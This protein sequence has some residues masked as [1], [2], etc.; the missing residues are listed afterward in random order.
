MILLL[1]DPPAAA[2]DPGDRAAAAAAITEQQ[3]ALAPV[4]ADLGATITFRYRVLVDAVAVSVPAGRVEALGALAEVAAVVPVGLPVAGAGGAVDARR[5]AVRRRRRRPP[6]AGPARRARAHRPDRRG[7]GRLAPV[8][9]RRHRPDVPDHRR[10]RPGRRRRRPVARR[11]RPGR[12]RRTARRWRAWCCATPALQGLPPD[13]VPRLLAYRV[14]TGE[15]AGGRV[16][17]LARTDRVL[18]ALERAVDPD[19]NGDPADRADVILL[20]VAGA[21]DGGGVDPVAQAL[22]AADRVGATVVAPAGNDGPTFARPGAVGGPAAGRTVLAVGGAS[23][24]TA[25][26][27]AHLDA[28]LGPASARLGR[29]AADGRGAAAPARSRWW[30]CATTPA[31][32]RAAATRTSARHRAPA[33]PWARSCSWPAA[34]R[35]SPRPPAGRP[36]RARGRCWCGTRTATPPSPPCRGRWGCRSPWW[37][38]GPARARA[39]LR[40]ADTRPELR[41]SVTADP[42]GVAPVGVASFSSW[43][44]TADGRQKPDLVAPAVDRLAAWPGRRRRRQPAGRAAH[45]DQRRRRRGGRRRAAPAR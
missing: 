12:W 31:W 15:P 38:S 33:A 25:P 4:L 44:P 40:L 18:A 24:G 34:T 36:P 3:D 42:A 19:G 17:A 8:A 39:L 21:F 28:R 29:P 20:G 14:V 5:G 2:A 13:A 32:R 10:R 26:R 35:R 11:R 7:R 22:A 16:Q 23:A 41:V 9:R 43:G 27:T 30:R 45:R 1:R 6:V 37:A